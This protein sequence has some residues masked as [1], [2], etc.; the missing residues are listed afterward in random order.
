MSIY[1]IALHWAMPNTNEAV[2]VFH[3]ESDYFPHEPGGV[4]KFASDVTAYLDNILTDSLDYISAQAST[5]YYN[6]YLVIPGVGE[7]LVAAP[8][9]LRTGGATGDILPS[10]NSFYLYARGFLH[11]GVAKKYVTGVSALSIAD[12]ILTGSARISFQGMAER[13]T[14]VFSGSDYILTPGFMSEAKVDGETP[15]RPYFVPFLPDSSGVN[16][17]VSTLNRRKGGRGI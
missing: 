13:W 15:A 6:L 12:G 2:N 11:R 8:I 10:Q 14:A 17:Q 5:I 16:D 1:K 7:S 9:Y 4:L 3:F